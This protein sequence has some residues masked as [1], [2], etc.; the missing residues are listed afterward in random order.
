MELA[1]IRP[2][3][4]QMAEI[5][6]FTMPDAV[7]VGEPSVRKV[8]P[9]IA[10]HVTDGSSTFT[11]TVNGNE[12]VTVPVD[13]SGGWKWVVDR[14]VTS[15]EF[16]GVPQLESLELNK[17][18]GVSTFNL[19]Y[20]VVPVFKKCDATTE[21]ALNYVYHIRGTATA[22][23]M[24]QPTYLKNGSAEK[25]TESAVIDA[26]GNWD[27][28]YSGKKIRRLEESFYQNTVITSIEFTENFD[29]CIT[30]NSGTAA[31]GA[32]RGCSNL[33]RAS[34]KNGTFD[35]ITA[36][37]NCFRQCSLLEEVDFSNATFRLLETSTYIFTDAPKL[38][39]L[40]LPK[41]TL[42]KATSLQSF[43][44]RCYDLAYVNCPIATLGLCDS[45]FRTF[46]DCTGLKSI[47]FGSA[48]IAASLTTDVFRNASALEN[49]NIK[50]CSVSL[51]LG[52]SSKLTEQSVVNIFNAVAAD[53][54]T[55][56]FHSTV[57]AMIQAQLEIE[58]SP[59]YN[60]YWDSD[61]DFTI[62]S[63]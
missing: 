44:D 20:P 61:Y 34:F 28:S 17:I 57:Y 24:F 63:A 7:G 40:D 23:F 45:L 50:S 62:A 10:G 42:E 6:L 13:A 8:K 1:E 53:G 48:T 47:D 51:V 12:S 4:P 9:Y 31:N 39:K 58:D 15:L 29:S 11:F 3:E 36:M 27:V 5:D 56:T 38:K 30:F 14:T 26:N 59:I 16:V 33:K 37:A 46:E 22:D 2:F 54:I 21:A 25:P 52:H 35:V 32:F 60:A 19:D 49:L 41:A 18:T 55:L 43:F